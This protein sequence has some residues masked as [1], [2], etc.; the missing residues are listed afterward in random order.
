MAKPLVIVESP[1]KAKTIAG[2]LG[3]DYMVESSVG[4]IRDLPSDAD[5][6]PAS[7]KGEPW[8][9]LGVDVDNG[10]KP[11]YV[12]V[13]GKRER[14]TRLRSLLKDASELYLATDEDR[15]GESIAWHLMEVLNPRVPVK[16]MV[17]HEITREA[18]QRAV[19]NWRELDRRLVDAQETRRILDRLYGYEVSPVL[20][21]KVLPR[22]SAGRVQSVA[23]RLLVERERARM[24]FR[25]AS[26]WDIGGRFSATEGSFSALLASVDG[27][28]LASG[29]DF[30]E[31]GNLSRQ[32]VLLLDEAGAR[33][34]AERLGGARFEV[35]STE[36]KPWRRSPYPPFMTSTLQQEASRKLRLPAATTM[37]L[38]QD[39]Y[40]AGYITYM[41]T[42]STTLSDQALDAARGAVRELYGDEYLPASPRR[43]DKKV[44]NAQEAHEAIRPAGE[45][46]RH[47]E[48]SGLRG[49]QLRLYDLI[50]KRT[51][52]S[53]MADA[54]GTSLQARIGATSSAGEEA[55]F[56]ANGRVIGFPGFLRAYVEGSDDPEAQLEDREV[57]LPPLA[58]GQE[59][60]LQ[61]LS[62]EG[63]STQP[64][65]RYTE[66]SLVKA[67]EELGVG[68]PSTYATIIGT[69]QARDYVWKKGTALVPSWT[70]F[71]VVGLL[72]K[73]F[74]RLVDY[75]FT[76][77]MEEDLDDIARG[78]GEALPWLTRFYFGTPE[79]RPQGG[80]AGAEGMGLKQMVTDRLAEIDA[81]AV[82]S[83]PI[84][85]GASG[86]VVRVGKY[87]AYLQS[88]DGE[89]RVSVPPDLT[90]DE[91]TVDRARELLDAPPPEKNDRE[92]GQDPATGLPVL[93][94]AG[95]FGPY[96][97]LGRAEELSTKPRTASLL[98][99][100]V[101][102]EIDL[103]DALRLLTLPR[104][105]GADPAS[106]EEVVADNGRYGP[107]VRRG[108][109]YRSL[110]S[111]GQLF[112]VSLDEALEL[113]SK[114]RARRSRQAAAPL[115]ELGPDP[116]T[117]NAVVVKEGRF[118]PYVTDGTVNAS[119]RRGDTIEALT[120][121]RAA[122]LL[123]ERRA[124]AEA[125]AA[126]GAGPGRRGRPAAKKATKSTAA[127]ST[128]AK[129]T[130]T[131]STTVPSTTTTTSLASQIC[132]MSATQQSRYVPPNGNAQGLTPPS[133]D[134]RTDTVV[135]PFY[136]DYVKGRYNPSVR[137]VL[138]PAEMTGS[139]VASAAAEVNTQTDQWEVVLNFTGK[140]SN[141]FNKYAAAHYACYQQNPSNP[142]FCAQQAIE[143]DAT[144]ESAP[145][146]E[147]A[148]FPGS[149]TISGSTSAPF[150][151]QQAT[152][153]A[154]ALNY[155]SLPVRFVAQNISNV[156]P[157]IGTD[158]LK[159]GAI[160]GAVAVLL[161]L[162]YLLVYYRALGLVVVLGIC[163]SG[164][165]LYS[166]TTLLSQTNG[167]ALTLSGVI[168]L[169]V[170]V[171]V[172]ADSCVVYFERLKEEVRSGRTVRASV[173][174]GFSR[175]F[176]TI[177]AADFSSFIAAL[178]LYILTVG[179][180]RGFAFFL[181][182]ATLL[183]VVTTYFFTRPLV[184]LMGRRS[185][186][187]GGGVLG[188]GRGLGAGGYEA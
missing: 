110:E 30:D 87:G 1:A 68:R 164:A 102:E 70:G 124:R 80:P 10:F 23:T 79:G 56:G 135:L 106:G 7:L 159:A 175:A 163:M 94:R 184:I 155:G 171:G 134:N 36:E 58:V 86:I 75:S 32:G 49:D 177:L 128:G 105:L 11:L 176:R 127:K 185:A 146:I 74:G 31:G 20:W 8:A 67:L 55:E 66:A 59:L 133:A 83:I 104:A 40:E 91:L 140:G 107:Y 35:R 182:L 145:A 111:E 187:T 150:T 156:S 120:I 93:V 92:L 139:I 142:P 122:E 154:N 113:F 5:E 9:R 138:G 82:N 72:E 103:A 64:P 119:L 71:A 77:E 118:G 53:Q 157:Q 123:A 78:G 188:V 28:R 161:V 136:A 63:H 147:A 129:S 96:V 43:Y 143:L 183:N 160:A 97:Q 46:F 108:T 18:I 50:W 158:S 60:Q 65:A 54:R 38:A 57:R 90:P 39:L 130:G 180:V 26:Y 100:M 99:G 81:R 89:K 98:S 33:A 167:L 126:S 24:R 76:A 6:I 137:Y 48:R 109:E 12:V 16:R 152:D 4:H 42:D 179:D 44:K 114:P 168:G 125:D 29:R 14:V 144:V 47:P 62:P 34:L 52:A 117:G 22:L 153:L 151:S 149:A 51:V 88:P 181:G 115:A 15:E 112:T 95:R 174:K 61:E 116:A 170:S 85:D 13:P 172:T 17:F 84:G 165:L 27:S 45:Q 3:S 41:R 162:I 132:S 186:L 141:E 19:E 121:E 178:V 73:Y 69:I 101:P 131:T 37:R 2:F 169:I 25:A 21:R 173:E 166:I 148:S